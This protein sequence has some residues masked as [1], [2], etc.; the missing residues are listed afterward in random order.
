METESSDSNCKRIGTRE[1]VFKGLALRTAGG[2]KRD[3]IISKQLGSKIIYISKKLSAK[4]KENFNII[5]ASNP[6]YFK[7]QIKRTMVVKPTYNETASKNITSS[8]IEPNTS[9]SLIVNQTKQVNNKP[10]SKTMKLAFKI[11]ENVEKNIYY[12]ELQGM[13]IIELK[14]EL[15]REEAEEDLGLPKKEF[16]I[17]EMPDITLDDLN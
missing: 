1:E 12:K 14:E 6:N 17:E 11:D 4:M 10:A 3:D 2:L 16:S 8:T 7:K 13:N 5:R 9:N 15:K